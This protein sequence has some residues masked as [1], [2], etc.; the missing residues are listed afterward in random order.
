MP[1]FAFTEMAS[2]YDDSAGRAAT[3]AEAVRAHMEAAGFL[4]NQVEGAL[5]GGITA[6]AHTELIAVSRHLADSL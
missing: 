4:L 6:D 2:M 1:G 5:P 3:V